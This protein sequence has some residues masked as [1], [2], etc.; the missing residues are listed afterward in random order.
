MTGQE[1]IVSGLFRLSNALIWPSL[2]EAERCL[3]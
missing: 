1:G 2:E 3:G